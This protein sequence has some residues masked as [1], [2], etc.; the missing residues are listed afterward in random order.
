MTAA[1]ILELFP[2]IAQPGAANLRRTCIYSGSPEWPVYADVLM[3]TCPSAQRKLPV[4][5]LHGAFHTGS[6][7]LTTPDGRAGWAFAFVDRGHDVYIPDWPGHGR[8]A[9]NAPLS[10]LST[11]DAAMSLAVLVKAIGPAILVAHSAAGPIAWWITEQHPEAVAAVVGVA[12][13]PPANLLKEL[14]NDPAELKKLEFDEEAGCPV[15]ASPEIPVVV[16]DTFIRQFWAN[17]PRFPRGAIDS[18]AR[19]IV[20]ESARILNERFNIGGAGLRVK[21]IERVRQRP[22]MVVTGDCDPRHPAAVDARLAEFLGAR[23]LWLPSVGCNGNGHL[24]MCEDNSDEV[25]SHVLS[26]LEST[27]L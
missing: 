16:T 14:P 22:I 21:D 11:E 17:S 15:F 3:A 4:V 5:M 24:P 10:A 6:V 2:V 20:P 8:S 25:V 23:F 13:G 9:L 7:F 19:S 18:Y 12:P 27:G 26:W 1:T